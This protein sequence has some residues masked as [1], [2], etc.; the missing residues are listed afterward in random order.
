M[1]GGR[2]GG[3]L[4][5]EVFCYVGLVFDFCDIVLIIASGVFLCFFFLTLS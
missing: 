5:S 2:E 1:G 3:L 4:A